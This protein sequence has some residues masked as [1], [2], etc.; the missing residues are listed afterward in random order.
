MK[1]LYKHIYML[2]MKIILNNKLYIINGWQLPDFGNSLL[3]LLLYDQI[4]VLVKR[5]YVNHRCHI[6]LKVDLIKI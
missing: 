4:P 1:V 5:H 3:K 6:I 2:Y